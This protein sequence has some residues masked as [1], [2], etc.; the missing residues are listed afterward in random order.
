MIYDLESLDNQQKSNLL[1]S[2][3]LTRPIALVT[4][5]ND[6]TTVN[7]APFSLFN[8]VSLDPPIAYISIQKTDPPKRTGINIEKM[9]EFVI[10]IPHYKIAE[11]M[12]KAA[13]SPRFYGKDK[14]EFC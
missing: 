9:R 7:I 13:S 1:L 3:V 8:L 10:N 12:N 11:G 6:D 4:S 2:I 5:L 14:F